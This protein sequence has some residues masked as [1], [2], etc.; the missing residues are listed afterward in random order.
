MKAEPSAHGPRS[1]L[2]VKVASI[3]SVI[4][5]LAVLSGWY[6]N[7]PFLKSILPNA[8]T[9]KF[10][11]AL[12]FLCAGISLWFL[13]REEQTVVEKRTGQTFAGLVTVLASLTLAEYL[14]GWNPGIDQFFIEDTV[15]SSASFPGRMSAVTALC[16]FFTGSSLLLIHRRASQYFSLGVLFLSLT[17]LTG[18][19]FGHD[20]L[21]QIVGYGTIA[22]HT[23]LMFFILSLAIL[24][25]RPSLGFMKTITSNVEGSRAM[26]R[27]L[28]SMAVLTIFLGWLV[29]LGERAG[30]LDVR[31]D[32]VVLV[33]LMLVVY[34]PLIYFHGKQITKTEE[35]I[36][37][38]TRL[39][40]TLSQVNQAIVHSQN[41]EALFNAICDV[42]VRYGKFRMAW[43]GLLERVTGDVQ[44]VAMAG[45]GA[46]IFE[47]LKINIDKPP[48]DKGL[49]GETLHHQKI[50]T[51]NDIQSDERMKYWEWHSRKHGYHSAVSIPIV[52]GGKAIGNLNLYA[53]ET[54]YF[55]DEEEVRL[56]EEIGGDISF[57]L[58][59][60]ETE[61]ERERAQVLLRQS[62]EKFSTL[63]QKAAF[64]ASLSTMPDG[65]IVDVNEA[66]EKAF[67]YTRREVI[68][69]TSLELGINPDAEGRAR[70]MAEWQEKGSVRNQEMPLHTK[71]GKVRFFS[72][73]VDTMEAGDRKYILNTAQDVT[74]RRQVE[75]R[76]RLQA[77]LLSKARDAV[78]ASDADYHITYWNQAAESLYG[79]RS[80]EVIGKNGTKIIQ[81]EFPGNDAEEMRQSIREAG[82]WR[83]EVVQV[84]KDGTFFQC[85]ISSTVLHD[86]A[87]RVTGYISVN[88][89]I[90]E[91]KQEEERFRLAIESAPNA[92]IMVN[93]KGEIVLA[94]PKT[95]IYFGYS[96][97]ELIGQS[98]DMLVPERFRDKHLGYRSGF[99]GQ[100]IPR[101]MG[102]GRELYGLRKDG[103]EFPVEIGLAPIKTMSDVMVLATVV[104]I[105]ERKHAEN[106]LLESETRYHHVL[107]SMME[108]CQ[109][110]DFD[111]Q[112]VYVNEVVAQQGRYQKEELLGHSM[113]EMYPGIENTDLFIVLRRCM[114][115]RE[116]TRMENEFTFP[117]GSPGWFELSIQPAREGIFILSTDI[118]ERKQAEAAFKHTLDDLKRSNAELEQFAYVA[119]HDL[120]EPLRMVSSYLQLLSRR[121]QEKLDSDADDFIN[122]AVDGARRM[123][124]LIEDLLSF[125]RI[126]TRGQ[127][128]E[129]VDA[130]I[131]L[132]KAL[133]N[134]ALTI[135]ETS[136]HIECASLPV[137]RA[138][139][140]QLVQLFQNLIG[141]GIKFCKAGEQPYIE[142]SAV[143]HGK[144]WR[145][146]V[147]DN[148]IGIDPQFADRIFVIFQRL[149]PRTDY[150]GTGIGLAI[151]K[152]IVER[153]GGRIWVKSEPGA[154]AAFYFTL[155]MANVGDPL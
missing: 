45:A 139:P 87:G 76:N 101:P 32:A 129:A 17:A 13:Q 89:D 100:P 70:I 97:E 14:F 102:A 99:Y 106:L 127:P 65:V 133:A 69:K 132:D 83:G 28:P 147:Q 110:I 46:R 78:I 43:I 116:P 56:L 143:Q 48:F 51:S 67:E 113:M 25:A 145:F 57:A 137:V 47:S 141:N 53:T 124:R 86:E 131:T 105:T 62:E 128:F 98:V 73:S 136:A 153:H 54:G 4:I 19:L 90:T 59:T 79:W 81:T 1:Q 148:G 68:G 6:L 119:S 112:Y 126:G 93:Q 80:E 66:F 31:S 24:L 152:K 30:L 16:F 94:N 134:L 92:V 130:N 15:T 36:E 35:K 34:A 135:G 23:A 142:I 40:A 55:N 37:R 74:E 123:Q 41:R 108:G 29:K 49:V 107:D 22:V 21:Y 26:R 118:T 111:W 95:E 2:Y 151:C 7:I 3:A 117:N 10:N 71:S 60:M 77:D 114:E 8:A 58:N 61:M 85:E 155:P 84:R 82:F 5:G 38:I 121:Y 96:R 150:P 122:F 138:D 91:R 50:S 103:S 75:E 115:E 125:S 11:T 20:A 33:A 149:H 44:P 42:I 146:T 63:F 154:G 120:Q 64:A 39:Y 140:G 12:G 109:I 52:L 27:L 18:Y 104:D 144:E 72:V 88:R 9:M